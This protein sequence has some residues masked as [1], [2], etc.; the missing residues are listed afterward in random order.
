MI[1]HANLLSTDEFHATNTNHGMFQDEALLIFSFYFNDIHNH[2]YYY[3]ISTERLKNYFDMFISHEG[4]HLE[5]SPIYHFIIARMILKLSKF[6]NSNQDIENYSYYHSLYKKMAVYSTFVIKPDGTL[7]SLG[8]TFNGL[9]GFNDLWIDNEEYIYSLSSG[10][11]GDPPKDSFKCFKEAGYVILRDDWKEKEN[12]VYIN[13]TA[14]YHTA[15]HKHSDD[16][17]VWIYA[18]GQDIVSE[19]GPNGYDYNNE[20]TKFGYSSFAHNTLIVNNKGLPRVDKKFN[21]TK[22]ID[23]QISPDKKSFSATGIN[24]RFK[25]ITHERCIT[26]NKDTKILIVE[27]SISS[28]K[29]GNNNYKLL[30]HLAEGII[31]VIEEKTIN[32]ISEKSN[33]EIIQLTISSNHPVR[34]KTVF[35]QEKPQLLGWHIKKM[36]KPIKTYT[37]IID[38]NSNKANYHIPINIKSEFIIN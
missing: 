3:H 23:Y 29:I 8:D 19:A 26:F 12:A 32:L 16:L 36:N 27:D 5:H 31:P 21:S 2:E 24:K 35:G 30:W 13:F 17:S 25:D 34:I 38:V 9:K 11:K 15:Y 28:S 18:N 33:E 1:Y 7:P 4:V 20:F 6:F 10:K 22:I 14:A 37:L